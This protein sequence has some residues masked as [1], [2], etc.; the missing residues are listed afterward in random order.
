MRPPL[1]KFKQSALL[2]GITSNLH[3]GA[4]WGLSMRWLMEA[5]VEGPHRASYSMKMESCAS[6][7]IINHSKFANEFL[8]S[9][10][11]IENDLNCSFMLGGG[12][13]EV[14]SCNFE[15]D[16]DYDN[17]AMSVVRNM[18]SSSSFS[19][20]ILIKCPR[21]RHAIAVSK[22]GGFWSLFDPNLGAWIISSHPTFPKP[23]FI[24]MLIDIFKYYKVSSLRMHRIFST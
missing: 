22:W 3:S 20:L 23:I 17:N 10:S 13:V 14:A 12:H 24:F 18:L 2:R 4:C 7:A 9:L 15:Y 5:K 6:E 8:P 16:I 19:G 11:P 21:G 1:Y